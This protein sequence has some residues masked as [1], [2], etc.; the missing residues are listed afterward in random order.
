MK[1]FSNE[2]SVLQSKSGIRHNGDEANDKLLW[3]WQKRVEVLGF[4]RLEKRF[5]SNS[6]ESFIELAFFKKRFPFLAAILCMT[7]IQYS[8]QQLFP[9]FHKSHYLPFGGRVGKHFV[10][11][12][13][14]MMDWWSL[15][16]KNSCVVVG[17][18]ILGPSEFESPRMLSITQCS[19]AVIPSEPTTCFHISTV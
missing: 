10:R 7:K 13:G 9:S 16:L 1:F 2:K 5:C 3:L 11:N 18:S 14:K 6:I 8:R 12:R 19:T 17:G 15:G 4:L